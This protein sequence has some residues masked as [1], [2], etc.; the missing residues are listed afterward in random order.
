[1]IKAVDILEEQLVSASANIVSNDEDIASLVTD[2]ATN[3]ASIASTDEELATIC[4]YH[5]NTTSTTTSK[6]VTATVT[7]TTTTTSKG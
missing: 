4:K 7:T 6:T 5:P 2:T 1:M 3:T